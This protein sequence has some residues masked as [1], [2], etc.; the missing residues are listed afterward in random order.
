MWSGGTEQ[1]TANL[2]TWVRFTTDCQGNKY[3]R[4]PMGH[5]IELYADGTW[6]SEAD[7]SLS[8]PEYLQG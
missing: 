1:E 6:H 7:P 4:G 5:I 2:N 3:H 8:L